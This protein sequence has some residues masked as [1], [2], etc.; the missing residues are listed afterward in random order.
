[1]ARA[2]GYWTCQRVTQAAKCG[3]KNP[4]RRRKCERCQKPRPVRQRPAHMS[5]LDLPYSY[6]VEI[7]GGEF[8]GI[9][10]RAPSPGRKLDRDHEHTS[11]GFP[12]GLLCHMC[13]RRLRGFVTLPWLARATAYLAR[14]ELRRGRA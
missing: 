13:N 2:R 9:C 8:C 3:H 6:Y 4:N 5:A 12:R 14:A 11:V 10:G 1:M 7:N